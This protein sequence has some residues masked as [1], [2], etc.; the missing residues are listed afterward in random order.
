VTGNSPG[1]GG[2]AALQS[3]FKNALAQRIGRNHNAIN[4]LA[5]KPSAF[6]HRWLGGHGNPG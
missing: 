1:G 2:H 4:N 5:A 3:Q 6:E